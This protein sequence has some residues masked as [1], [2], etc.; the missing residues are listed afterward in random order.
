MQRGIS[1]L[2]NIILGTA[3]RSKRHDTTMFLKTKNEH[4]NLITRCLILNRQNHVCFLFDDLRKPR[5]KYT[6]CVNSDPLTRRLKDKLLEQTWLSPHFPYSSS[7]THSNEVDSWW[8]SHEI[9]KRHVQ[10]VIGQPVRTW[11]GKA[12]I[13]INSCHRLVCIVRHS[14]S[15]PSCLHLWFLLRSCKELGISMD[16]W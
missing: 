16:C 12:R 8:K 15:C 10:K 13:R 5:S 4:A 9:L 2:G 6:T 14:W 1:W 11:F 7:E 3:I